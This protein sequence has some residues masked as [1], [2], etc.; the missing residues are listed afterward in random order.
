M[1]KEI[2]YALGSIP[3][4]SLPTTAVFM[5]EV[6]GY[7]KLYDDINTNGLGEDTSLFTAR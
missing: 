4:M 3:W 6:R 5:L 7:S 2:K 1:R